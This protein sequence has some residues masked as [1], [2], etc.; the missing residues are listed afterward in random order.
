MNSS[1]INLIRNT[2]GA[3]SSITVNGKE[4]AVAA[5][6]FFTLQ[7]LDRNGDACKLESSG[8]RNDGDIFTGHPACPGLIVEFKVTRHDSCYHFR[9]RVTGVPE[10]M[11]L[12]WFDGPQIHY[13][14]KFKL[15]SP[16]HDGVIIS[17]TTIPN[18]PYHPIAFA[19]RGVP[20]GTAFPGRAQVQFL[21]VFDDDGEG[22]YFG[23]HDPSCATKAVEYEV[24]PDSVRLSLQTFSGINYG[25]DYTPEFDYIIAP[26]NAGWRGAAQIYRDYME[27]LYGV[28]QHKF[29]AALEASPVILIYP[30]RGRGLDAGNLE[31]NCYFPYSNAMPF[32]N[33]LSGALDSK[34]MALLMHWEGTAPW[35]P[36]Y[37]WPPYGGVEALTGF[38]DQLHQAGHLLGLY[39]S[40]VAWT[41]RSC[42]SPDYAP[43]C[44]EEQEKFM[45]RGPKGE[46]EATICNGENSQRMGYDMCMTEAPSRA[47]AA[48]EI[49]AMAAAGVDYAQFYDQ[50]HGGAMH[51]C[52][53]ADHNHPPVPG[54]WQA[55]AMRSF[56]QEISET[57]KSRNQEMLL[58]CESAAA[59]PF[60]EYLALNDARSSFVQRIGEVVPLQQYVFHGLSCNFCGNQAGASAGVDLANSPADLRR[61]LAYGFNAGDLLSLTLKDNGKIHW[62]WQYSWDLP[63]PDQLPVLTLVRNLNALRRKH[64]EVFLY[65]RMVLPWCNVKQN[66]IFEQNKQGGKFKV[67]SFY[68]NFWET[69]EGKRFLSICNYLEEAQELEI[70]GQ[71]RVIPPL[72]ALLIEK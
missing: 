8:F 34:C 7:L 22:F 59:E 58:G 16:R 46:L 3:V 45:L 56:M 26:V 20:Y 33:E 50:N 65:G 54:P 61:R 68:C 11:V 67:P 37:V 52:Y 4:F 15:L 71:I 38:R 13:D 35:A 51:N 25:E 53:A 70:D 40:G 41:C 29:P 14:K 2:A 9:P 69:R 49:E 55:R 32:I 18:P 60:I 21:A 24:L 17:D 31:P 1:D 12:E 57:L 10:N 48:G 30:V 28:R 27:T 39:C 66:Y 44:S 6:E 5:P 42:I 36:P 19:K 64:P 63:E 43:G 47:I 62:C 72:N 23:A